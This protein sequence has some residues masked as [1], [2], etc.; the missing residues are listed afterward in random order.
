MN[1]LYYSTIMIV[2]VLLSVSTNRSINS[3]HLWSVRMRKGQDC[4]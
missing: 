2:T 4:N 3:W 1:L